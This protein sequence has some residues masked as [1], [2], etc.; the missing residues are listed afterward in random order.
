MCSSFKRPRLTSL[1][2]LGMP[3]GRLKNDRLMSPDIWLRAYGF[4]LVSPGI[5][6]PAYSS[7][8]MA[9][10]IWLWAYG[11]AH[12]APSV[13]KKH[14]ACCVSLPTMCAWVAQ[15]C[16]N[17]VCTTL[18]REVHRCAIRMTICYESVACAALDGKLAE[19]RV[20]VR[21]LIN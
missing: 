17:R 11:A 12:M 14:C 5:C 20:H 7:G 3:V 19:R 18:N 16:P 1:F 9:L 15:S 13:R 2:K 8:R 6:L 10:G 21:R 4:G